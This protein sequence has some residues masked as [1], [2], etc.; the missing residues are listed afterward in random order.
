MQDSWK[1]DYELSVDVY[2]SLAELAMQFATYEE[3]LNA[4]NLVERHVK[5]PEDKFRVQ[6]VLIKRK[7]EN[8][9]RDYVGGVESVRKILLDY[10]VKFPKKIIP[11]QEYVEELK[12]MARLGGVK[13]LF[14][15]VPKLVDGKNQ[16]KRTLVILALLTY[17]MEFTH[18]DPKMKR[19]NSYATLRIMNLSLKRG[20]SCDTAL[21]IV[22]FSGRCAYRRQIKEANEW[23]KISIQLVDCFPRNLG[24]RH[25]S[26]YTWHMF[27]LIADT[28]SYRDMLDPFL[29]LNLKSFRAGDLA[30]GT[31]S[32]MA[33][34]YAYFNGGLPLDP[35]DQD[36]LAFSDEARQFGLAASIKVLFPIFRQMI[37]NLKVMQENPTSLDG[38]IFEQEEELKKFKGIGLKMTLRDINTFRLML[39]CMYQDWET[40]EKLVNTLEPCLYTDAKF[41]VRKNLLLCYMGC[42]C[43]IL[44]EMN[45]TIKGQ[46]FRQLGR[47]VI[48]ILKD[49]LKRGSVNAV[50][51]VIFLE[52]FESPSKQRFDEAIRATARLGLIQ[53]AAVLYE[54]AGQFFMNNGEKHWAKYYL[55]EASKLYKDWGAHGKTTQMLEKYPFLDSSAFFHRTRGGSIQGRTRFSTDSISEMKEIPL[56]TGNLINLFDTNDGMTHG[57]ADDSFIKA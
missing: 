14:L 7:L 30:R 22:G 39:S 2:S 31:M 3:A 24:S 25:S 51:M 10:G 27:G 19:L 28:Y 43:V 42:A 40:A 15:T 52:A 48:K 18:F 34:C 12:L 53:H 16:D 6:M 55:A 1:R 47:K 33:Y 41:V 29:E 44:G 46:K 45:K 57:T 54:N 11:G 21:A 35:L 23:G 8:G 56:Q 37:H 13:E 9:K 32:W 38:H 50:A 4:A 49:D 36:L 17:L 5:A 20:V 26:V